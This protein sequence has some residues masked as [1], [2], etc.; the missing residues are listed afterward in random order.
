MKEVKLDTSIREDGDSSSSI[1]QGSP[2]A[3]QSFHRSEHGAALTPEIL[4]QL[5]FKKKRGGDGYWFELKYKKWTFITNDNYYSEKNWHIGYAHKEHTSEFTFLTHC[6][7]VEYFKL[8]FFVLT[9]SEPNV[10]GS[11]TENNIL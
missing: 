10:Q 9:N 5:G 8:L 4:K 11:D 3:S 6:D 1:P 7:T 2:V